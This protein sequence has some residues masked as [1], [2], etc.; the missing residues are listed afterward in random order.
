MKD[1]LIRRRDVINEVHLLFKY[2]GKPIT[3]VPA[4]VVPL[5]F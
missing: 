4:W 2:E 1:D 5:L 3:E